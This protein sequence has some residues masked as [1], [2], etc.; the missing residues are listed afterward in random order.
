MDA[1]KKDR[2]VDFYVA[3]HDLINV[4]QALRFQ[5]D[6]AMEAAEKCK[7]LDIQNQ[8]NCLECLNRALSS[9]RV[10][11]ELSKRYTVILSDMIDLACGK[12]ESG[13]VDEQK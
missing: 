9:A 2:P 10:M 4:V 6:L 7:A 1:E 12:Q 8:V 5:Y 13:T 3:R 11:E